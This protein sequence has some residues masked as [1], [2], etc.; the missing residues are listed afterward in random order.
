MAPGELGTLVPAAAHAH[1]G[2][3]NNRHR[4][5]APGPFAQRAQLPRGAEAHDGALPRREVADHRTAVVRANRDVR[6][7]TGGGAAGARAFA[8]LACGEQRAEVARDAVEAARRHYEAARVARRLPVRQLHA[9]DELGLARDVDV[10]S[11]RPHARGD[12]G[13]TPQAVRPHAAH[14][15]ARTRAE[16]IQRGGIGHV[17]HGHAG[18]RVG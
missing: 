7:D 2:P 13:F 10:V 18:D 17:S 4:Q 12:H 5:R 11:A 1:L 8:H 6:L 14:D 16:R 3:S 9:L 15:D